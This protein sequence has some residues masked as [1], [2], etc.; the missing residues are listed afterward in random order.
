MRFERG[1]CSVKEISV[2]H[3]DEC[4]YLQGLEKMGFANGASEAETKTKNGC[5]S[6]AAICQP[7]GHKPMTVAPT[8]RH[9]GQR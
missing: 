8:P 9:S 2:S 5:V 6:S 4:R 7:K 3:G 1:A